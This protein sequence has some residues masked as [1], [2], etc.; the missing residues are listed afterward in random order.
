MRL[1]FIGQRMA[2]NLPSRDKIRGQQEKQDVEARG[3]KLPML[4]KMRR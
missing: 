1:S 4:A 3:V 2:N